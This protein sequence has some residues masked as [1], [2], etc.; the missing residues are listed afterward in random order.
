M[1]QKKLWDSTVLFSLMVES[2]T[3]SACKLKNYDI[4]L[5]VFGKG[6]LFRDFQ[7]L[8]RLFFFFLVKKPEETLFLHD[9][10]KKKSLIVFT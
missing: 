2:E 7:S 3:Q 10:G 6:N 8:R 4:K 1:F 5:A 9:L